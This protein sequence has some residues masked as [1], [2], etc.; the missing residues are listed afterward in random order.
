MICAYLK[1]YK[2]TPH[3][4][5]KSLKQCAC[6]PCKN[7]KLRRPFMFSVT[8]AH[9]RRIRGKKMF[10]I[11]RVE[12]ARPVGGSNLYCRFTSIKRDFLSEMDL[13]GIA[14]HFV[15][16]PRLLAIPC[17]CPVL[18]RISFAAIIV[19]LRLWLRQIIT[20]FH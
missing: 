18:F 8:R 5:T 15:Y 14:A 4:S 10:R 11:K 9:C 1:I 19:R 3:P 20:S 16:G 6:F 7:R 12:T 2:Y 13:S 17:V